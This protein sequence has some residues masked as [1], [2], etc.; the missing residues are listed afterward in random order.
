VATFW[1]G[2]SKY[3]HTNLFAEELAKEAKRTRHTPLEVE[4]F[5]AVSGM[6]VVVAVVAGS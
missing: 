1:E 2:H 5:V 6:V 3:L 4:K